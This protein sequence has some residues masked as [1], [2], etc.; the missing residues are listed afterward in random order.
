[1]CYILYRYAVFLGQS[2][3]KFKTGETPLDY[4]ARVDELLFKDF[5]MKDMVEVYYSVRFGRNVPDKNTLKKLF[6]FTKELK[7]KTGRD[8][9]I[10][11]G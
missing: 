5:N 3:C 6:E 1:M 7:F 4:A 8:M 2:G 9:N 10:I 11:K